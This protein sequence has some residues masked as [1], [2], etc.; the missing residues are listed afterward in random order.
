MPMKPGNAMKKAV[1]VTAITVL[2]A[3]PA[4]CAPWVR[5]YVVGNYEPAFFYGAKTGAIDPGSDCPK[6]ANP[7]NNYR[8]ILKTAWRSDDEVRELTRTVTETG[9]DPT[10]VMTNALAHRGF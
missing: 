8:Q 7:D 1:L 10:A 4:V 9:K 3:A 2:F 6:G 5:G